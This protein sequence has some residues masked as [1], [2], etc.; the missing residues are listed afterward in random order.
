MNRYAETDMYVQAGDWLVE[1]VRRKPEAL[2][3]LAAG[4]A[5]MMRNGRSSTFTDAARDYTA[6]RDYPRGTYRSDRSGQRSS[7]FGEQRTG[8]SAAEYASDLKNRVSD[9]ASSYANSAADVKN[10]VADAASSYAASATDMKNRVA[11]AASSYAA[12][13]ADYADQARR[14]ISDS[15]EYLASQ[16]QSAFDMTADKMRDQP[17]LVAAVGLAAGAAVAA[18]FP[19]T[20]LERRT[21]GEAREAISEAATKAGENLVGAA[22]QATERLKSGVAERGINPEGLKELARDV[23][24]TFTNAAAGKADQTRTPDVTKGSEAGTRGGR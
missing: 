10:R 7:Y 13:A 6:T 2:L 3:L 15:S 17:L 23:A 1:T 12:S 24:E 11:D 16:A 14:T 19:A 22:G 4:C 20:E 9:A 5:L 8:G 18:F 21:F